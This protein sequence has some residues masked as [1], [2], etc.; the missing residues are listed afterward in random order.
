MS[1]PVARFGTH[2]DPGT[3]PIRELPLHAAPAGHGLHPKLAL[4]ESRMYSSA[5]HGRHC[6]T[7][8]ENSPPMLF[9]SWCPAGQ[10][11]SL[12][13]PAT[14]IHSPIRNV[15][16]LPPAHSPPAGQLRHD[17]PSGV[18]PVR[19][20]TEYVPA[21]H[22]THAPL[23]ADDPSADDVSRERTYPPGQMCS[24]SARATLRTG[25]CTVCNVSRSVP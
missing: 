23:R 7:S 2:S 22:S 16:L 20:S 21:W 13:S 9:T 5:A 25:E 1:C 11:T 8:C 24:V 4:F 10:L 19:G 12:Y 6:C 14:T 17:G 18:T 15:T 3:S